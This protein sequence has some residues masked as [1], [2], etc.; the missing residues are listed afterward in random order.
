M[1]QECLAGR[2][3]D[4]AEDRDAIRASAGGVPAAAVPASRRVGQ[5]R[6]KSVL[7]DIRFG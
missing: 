6:P 7:P 5:A 4:D 3:A 1:V 2:Q